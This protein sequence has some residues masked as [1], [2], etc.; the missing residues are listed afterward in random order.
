LNPRPSRWQRDVLPLNYPRLGAAPNVTLE[1]NLVPG[2]GIA[3]RSHVFQ[4]RAV[5][6][7]ATLANVG[8][9]GLEPP[10]FWMD[11]AKC[12]V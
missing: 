6:T 5:T 7:L 4:T 11:I 9:E 2:L 3:P 12:L 1:L 10:T 8:G